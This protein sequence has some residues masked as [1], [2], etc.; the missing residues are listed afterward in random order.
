MNYAYTQTLEGEKL[1]LRRAVMSDSEPMFRN[2]GSDS[3]TTKYVLWD[4]HESVMDTRI[5]LRFWVDS[6]SLA[7]SFKWVI[8]LKSTG[9]QMGTIS[10]GSMNK[11][12][13]TCEVGYSLGS[14]YW[15]NGYA[16]EALSLVIKYLFDVVGCRKVTAMHMIENPASG[17]VMEKCGM[18]QTKILKNRVLGGTGRIRTDVVCYELTKDEY[19]SLKNG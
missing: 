17:R 10:V 2:W 19:D 15:G 4:T 3:K 13:S 18:K 8:T 16:T 9:E 1:I 5:F 12:T 6:Y 14:K 7:D 11:L